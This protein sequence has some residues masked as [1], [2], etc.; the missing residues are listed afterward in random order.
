M[1]WSAFLPAAL[2]LVMTPGAGTLCVWRAFLRGGW[3]AG[4]L[5]LAGLLLGDMLLILLSAL[6]VAALLAANPLLFAV[7]RWGGAGYLIYL[8]CQCWRQAALPPV[9][10][11]TAS[12]R[13]LYSACLLT[14]GNPKAIVFFMAFF[15]QFL[16]AGQ[17][18]LPGFLQLGMVFCLLNL[19]Y[20]IALLWLGSRLCAAGSVSRLAVWGQRV[21]GLM[22]LWLGL[23]CLWQRQPA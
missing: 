7:L 12:R 9:P 3:H 2:L 4:G 10:V 16:P 5:A 15:P 21:S 18:I 20:L 17:A 19:S 22:M 23:R 8:G 11:T 6:G 13:Q 1:L 14:L